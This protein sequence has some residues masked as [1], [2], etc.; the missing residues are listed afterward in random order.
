MNRDAVE[1]EGKVSNEPGSIEV[2]GLTLERLRKLSILSPA[3]SSLQIAADWLLIA[4]AIYLGTH[5]WSPL[6]YVLIV[7][8]IGSRQHALLIL[9]HDGTHYRLFRNRRLNDCVGELLLAWPFF[10]T[11]RS[12]RRN[13]I[14]HHRHMNT[15]R[16]PDW[17][18][19]LDQPQWAFPKHWAEVA[20]LLFGDVSGLNAVALIRLS[21]SLA[22]QD[23]KVPRWYVLSRLGF[24]IAAAALII[25]GSGLHIHMS[26]LDAQGRNVFDNGSPEGSDVLRHV[27]GGL[28]A[29]M[30][31]SMALFAPSVNSY[32]RFQ[33]DMFAPVNRRW[34]VNN[35]SAGLR[36]PVGPG[37][38]RRVEHRV[39]GADANPY[40][41]L[42]AVLAGAHHG[43]TNKIDPGAPAQGN[44]SREPDL[45]LP[46][47]IQDALAKLDQGKVLA[48]YIGAET[49][50]LYGETK[51]IEAQRLTRI[52]SAAEHDW[53][54]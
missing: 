8:L 18:R 15:D 34:G 16:D 22:G 37:E 28:Q 41:A 46:F 31:E 40:Y 3:R 54:L 29:L 39:S 36:V 12:Y 43:L 35:R 47:S 9:M 45:A 49:V 10:I 27:I 48:A 14:A 17:S 32:R 52:I 13:H 4:G 1:V 20:W 24:Y 51:R 21:R 2:A 30:P 38:A 5:Q 11:M 19:K 6:L 42:A 7:V 33:P 50:K 44:V 53:Y 26:L 25:A 23:G